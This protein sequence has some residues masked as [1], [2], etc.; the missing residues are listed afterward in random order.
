MIDYV[1]KNKFMW[2][3]G[4][5]YFFVYVVRTGINDWTVLFLREE[6]GYDMIVANGV[7]SLF[8]VGGF[9]G[10]L[11]AGWFSDRIFNAKRGPVN[12]IFALGMLVAIFMFYLTPPGH[13]YLD[14]AGLF[15]IGFAVFGPQMLIGVAAAELS[16]KK[17]AATSTG[18]TGCIAY[19]GAAMAGYPLGKIADIV[20]WEG[21][22]FVLIGCCFCS[23]LFL[24]PMWAVTENKKGKRL[25]L[26][27]EES[28]LT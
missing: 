2:M 20:G 13:P 6:K 22:F 19:F 28:G 16:H 18:F 27:D 7:V 24:I 3:L 26:A 12:V 9:F 1:L 5:A 14:S 8:E 11:C 25:S 17:A 21:F 15:S 23:V 10:A 4:L